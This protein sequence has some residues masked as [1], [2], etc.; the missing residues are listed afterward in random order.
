MLSIVLWVVGVVLL[1]FVLDYKHCGRDFY[2]GTVVA[3]DLV[4]GS[5]YFMISYLNL[6][7]VQ[8]HFQNVITAIQQYVLY[9]VCPYAL[10]AHIAILIY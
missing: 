4:I 1:V 7:A 5:R 10:T 6:V 3:V 2:S 8:V 9:T